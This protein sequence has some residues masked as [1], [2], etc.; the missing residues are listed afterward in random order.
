MQNGYGNRQE[1]RKRNVNSEVGNG[2]SKDGGQK[3]TNTKKVNKEVS[4]RNKF[5]VLNEVNTNEASE[6]GILNDKMLV[7]VYLNKKIQ[8]NCAKASNSSKDMIK[9]FKDQWELDRLKEQEDQSKNM[10][11]VYENK[12]GMAQT[13]TGDNVI[14][15]S[16]GLKWRTYAVME[17]FH[18]IK[19]LLN[20]Q[21]SILKKLDK[22]MVNEEL[23]LK[24]PDANALFRP[25][26]VSDHSPVVV[27]LPLS[28]EKKKKKAFRFAN[29]ITEKED[30]L[31]TVAKCNT[32]KL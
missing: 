17:S 12:D 23:I 18:M 26:L 14:G 21:N 10:E 15:L 6:I 22:A 8:P 30:F 11:D 31:P 24:F 19:S 20:P 32:P 2:A 16:K 7:D 25:Y 9:Y 4:E 13:I 5:E 28:Y 29:Y 27:S 3:N 1:Y